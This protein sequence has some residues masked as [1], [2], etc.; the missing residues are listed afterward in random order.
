MMRN[1][2]WM[3]LVVLT[4]SCVSCIALKK[5]VDKVASDVSRLENRMTKVESETA[6]ARADLTEM[7]G[8]A[9]AQVEA[10]EETLNRATRVLARNSADFGAEMETIKGKL[11]GIDGQLAEMGHSIEQTDTKI[12]AATKKISEVASSAGLDVPVSAEKIPPDRPSHLSAIRD[13]FARA[14]H[15]EVR[16]L[17][18][19]FLERYPKDKDADSVQL[20]IA[21]SFV[22]QKRWANALGALGRFTE[23]YPNSAL[24]PE[25]LYEMARGFFELGDCTDARNLVEAIQSKYA[26]SPFAAKAKSLGEQIKNQRQRCT[27]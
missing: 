22:E 19:A 25:A 9:R 15:G 20:L 21:K 14:R 11:R 4:L 10:L 18:Q 6:S 12:E 17:G 24:T 3:I 2:P 27:S 5:D 7:I 1:I 13:S 16:S 26:S 23:K 8:K